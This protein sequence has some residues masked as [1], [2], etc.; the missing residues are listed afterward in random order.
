MHDSG[1]VRLTWTVTYDCL[2]PSDC[3]CLSAPV[4][5]SSSSS[6]SSGSS[7]SEGSSLESKLLGNPF[8]GNLDMSSSRSPYY[9]PGDP[10][11][12]INSVI[13]QLQQEYDEARAYD[14]LMSVLQ[15]YQMR[16]PIEPPIRL[17]QRSRPMYPEDLSD[18]RMTSPDFRSRVMHAASSRRF[19]PPPPVTRTSSKFAKNG[20]NAGDGSQSSSGRSEGH[21][22]QKR[23]ESPQRLI[24]GPGVSGLAN[25]LTQSYGLGKDGSIGVRFGLS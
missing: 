12:A 4:P 7:S 6:S 1:C 18:Q 11:S 15:E 2:S 16:G 21:E 19:P 14:Q 5:L 10:M 23:P 25:F 9:M 17:V 3:V 22:Q 8:A 20:N 13:D 24:A